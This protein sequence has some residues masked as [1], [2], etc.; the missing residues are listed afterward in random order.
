M[1]LNGFKKEVFDQETGRFDL[2]GPESVRVAETL[3]SLA[4]SGAVPGDAITA[5]GQ[6][7]Q[8]QFA[9]GRYAVAMAFGP[10]YSAYV[11]SAAGYDASTL[12]VRAWPSF[13]SDSPSALLGPYWNVG[14]S[15]KSGNLGKAAAFV[16]H[17]YSKDASLAW[18]KKAGQVPD[19]RSVLKDPFFA[20][21]KGEVITDFVKIIEA[22]GARVLPQRIEDVTKLA[23]VLNGAV[24]RLL[25]TKDDITTILK[26]A[27]SELGWQ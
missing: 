1:L 24:Q 4:T 8:D 14:L 6:D 10:R 3:R 5:T 23:N 7:I 21:G 16:E 2:L 20:T 11:D 15:A 9:S 13:D 25:G 19:R 27:Q 12:K 22:D 26:D 17:L 18:A